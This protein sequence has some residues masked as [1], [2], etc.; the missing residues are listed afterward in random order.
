MAE[1]YVHLLV[2]LFLLFLAAA[3]L[4]ERRL[5]CFELKRQATPPLRGQ[6]GCFMV[7]VGPVRV[8]CVFMFRLV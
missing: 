3:A 8:C 7:E 4:E 6:G 2:L 1:G 5:W